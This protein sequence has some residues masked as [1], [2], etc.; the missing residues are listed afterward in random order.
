MNTIKRT[1]LGVAVAGTA[2]GVVG[3]VVLAT[4]AGAGEPPPALPPTTAE[5]LVASVLTAEVPALSGTVELDENLGLPLPI[6]PSGLADGDGTRVYSD[7]QGR[8]RITLTE[9][10]AE[11]TVVADGTTVW[12]WNSADRSVTK[13]PNSTHAPEQVV[14]RLADP[15]A[16]A[17]QLVS[18]MQ[19]DSTVIVDGTAR[20]AGR[21]AYQLVLMPK[22]TEKTLLRE[23]RVAVDAETRVPLALEVLANGQADPALKVGFTEFSPGPQD[24]NLFQ[25]T[26]PPGATVTERNQDEHLTPKA[27][28]DLFNQLDPQVVGQGWDS[29][30]VARIPAELSAPAG[31]NDEHPNAM[32]LLPQLGRPVSGPYGTGWMI[33]TKVGAALITDDGRVAIG[34]VPEPVLAEA[35]GQVK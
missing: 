1:A 30:L 28:Q 24:A 13:V 19:Q 12:I 17:K 11:R 5:T 20:V 27:G 35:L 3:L 21:P 23:V 31:G 15:A 10:N 2:A 29:V 16:A 22:P 34:A 25:F 14:E 18:A 33:D 4:P 32:S 6:L 9:H 26:P 7:G 8:G